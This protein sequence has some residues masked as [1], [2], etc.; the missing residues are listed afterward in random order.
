MERKKGFE[1]VFDENSR[2]LILGSFPSVKSREIRFYYGNRQNRFW[3]TVCSLYG[4]EIPESIAGKID[5]LHRNRIALWDIVTA[6]DIVGSSDSTIADYEV[7]DLRKILS[8]AK[9]EK[10]LCNGAAAYRI[11]TENYPALPVPVVKLPSTSPANP[12]FEENAWKKEL[13]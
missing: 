13:L 5:F 10:I 1:P 11:L 7:A 12:R 4:E 6:C 9:I 3:K 8:I 2:I